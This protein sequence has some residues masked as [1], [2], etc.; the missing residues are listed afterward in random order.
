MLLVAKCR[1]GRKEQISS[2][3]DK[4]F[5]YSELFDEMCENQSCALIKLCLVM[6]I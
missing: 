5:I 1:V 6:R 4:L 2:S 3:C